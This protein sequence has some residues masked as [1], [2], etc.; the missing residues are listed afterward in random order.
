MNL[1]L[2]YGILFFIGGHIIAW[3]QLNSQF[4][5]DWAKDHAWVMALIGIPCSFFYIYGTKFT[6]NGFDGLLWPTRFVGFGIGIII[7]GLL[8][9]YFFNEGLSAKTYIS[10]VLASLLICIQ[11][12]WK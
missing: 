4:K 12:L 7:Y 1:N 6:V 3:F 8:V 10:L 9:S 11:V 5:W 2:L